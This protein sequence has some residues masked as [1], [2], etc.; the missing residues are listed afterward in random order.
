LKKFVAGILFGATIA[1]TGSVFAEEIKQYILTPAA[2]P[3]IVN[4]TEYA[5]PTAPILNYE[6]STYVP[7]AKLGDL[8]GV[9]YQ[10]NDTAKR[11][12]IVTGFVA[13]EGD[14]VTTRFYEDGVMKDVD[15]IKAEEE[16]LKKLNEEL[17]NREAAEVTSHFVEVQGSKLF[18]AYDVNGK[19]MGL[20]SDDQ[21]VMLIEYLMDLQRVGGTASE[22]SPPPKLSDGWLSLSFFLDI[23]KYKMSYADTDD[24]LRII[25][26]A[27][28]KELYKFTWSVN[29]E[30]EATL[31]NVRVKKHDGTPYF[32]IQDLQKAGVIK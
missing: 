15:S 9:N 25:R 28:G 18:Q 27:E 7:L 2:Y 16:A 5:D 4:G 11:V 30:D 29:T 17:M 32:N 13:A 19:D 14:Q 21:D 6:G 26:S 1:T 8:T 12:E 23:F 22:E 3:I 20:F 24:T 10:W 31:N